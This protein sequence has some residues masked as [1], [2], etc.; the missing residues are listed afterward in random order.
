MCATSSISDATELR[1]LVCT[2]TA[3]LVVW[4]IATFVDVSTRPGMSALILMTPWGSAESAR[5][6]RFCSPRLNALPFLTPLLTSAVTVTFGSTDA[7]SDLTVLSNH[8]TTPVAS[9]SLAFGT[10]KCAS[11]SRG[12][13]LRLL[14]PSNLASR[15]PSP[16]IAIATRVAILSALPRP[17]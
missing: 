4:T 14:P 3:F 1:W 5:S 15:P 16:A 7:S 8:S 2:D 17:V 9:A 6:S 11:A 10:K 13:A 12:M